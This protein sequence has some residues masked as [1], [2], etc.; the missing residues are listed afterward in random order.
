MSAYTE[1]PI[2]RLKGRRIII[3]GAASGIGKS[4]AQLFAREGATVGLLDRDKEKLQAAAEEIGGTAFPVDI[5]DEEAVTSVITEAAAALSGID[6]VVNAAGVMFRGRAVDVTAQDW[7][8]V[9]DINLTG[10][11]NVLRGAIPWLSQEASSTIVTIAS[12]AGLLPN[13]PGYSAYAASKGGVIALTK[14]LAA[15]LAPAVRVNTVCPGMVDTAMADGYRGNVGNYALNRLADPVE[16]ARAILF[17]STPESS[18]I[19]GAALA[20]DGG[21]S[22]H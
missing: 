16:I 17:L 18:Y 20:A 11:Y 15:E 8:K 10:T 13:A 7:R 5:T 21:R 14:A 12:A 9:I 4:T 2:E 3:T 19:T 22:F 6:G 1:R